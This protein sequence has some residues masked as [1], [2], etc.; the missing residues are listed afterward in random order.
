[1]AKEVAELLVSSPSVLTPMKKFVFEMVEKA[2]DI[3][4]KTKVN[5]S[6]PSPP[7]SRPGSSLSNLERRRD[8]RNPKT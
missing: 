6:P 2:N 5:V 8:K 3:T 4:T 7:S 1:M